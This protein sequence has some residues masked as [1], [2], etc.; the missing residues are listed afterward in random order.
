MKIQ[1]SLQVVSVNLKLRF[2]PTKDMQIPF[3]PQKWLHLHETCVQCLVEWKNLRFFQFLFFEF[4][5]ILFTIYGDTPGFSS[6]SSTKSG[7]A[8]RQV[9]QSTETN[10]KSIFRLFRSLVFEIWSI[11]YF[12]FL[13]P[14]YSSPG[15]R[16]H[17]LASDSGSQK[18]LSAYLK[19][20]CCSKVAKYSGKMHIALKI[21][22]SSWFFC[23]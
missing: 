3:P 23:V 4:W 15:L 10:E 1:W 11:L 20:K 19:R 8:H 7:Q 14:T 5:L 16:S 13:H 18:S 22:I 12:F 2:F 9:A 21:I 6:V 17:W